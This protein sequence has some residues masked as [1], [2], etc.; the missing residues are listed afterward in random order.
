MKLEREDGRKKKKTKIERENE[1]KSSDRSKHY[2]R[3]D[4]VYCAIDRFKRNWIWW[5]MWDFFQ[6]GYSTFTYIIL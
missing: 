4:A 3:Y 5:S 6:Q 1:K 2:P